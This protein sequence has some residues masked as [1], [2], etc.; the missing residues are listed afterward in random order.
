MQQ[1]MAQLQMQLLQAQVQREQAEAQLVSVKAQV[2]P[3]L[4]QAK[5]VSAL[6]NNLNEDNETKDFE[7]RMKIA[8]LALKEKDLDI[9]QQTAQNQLIMSR[10]NNTNAS[11]Q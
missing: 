5:Y 2:E 1:Q 8:E 4:A 7:R 11:Y 9:K 6:S 3:Q 10:E